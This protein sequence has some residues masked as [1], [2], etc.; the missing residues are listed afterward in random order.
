MTLKQDRE[1]VTKF[2]ERHFKENPGMNAICLPD[3]IQMI[4]DY[5]GI[6][7]GSNQ[8]QDSVGPQFIFFPEKVPVGA[9]ISDYRD[10]YEKKYGE[11]P[12]TGF[13]RHNL[14]EKIII[15]TPDLPASKEK[16]VASLPGEKHETMRKPQRDT[17]AAIPEKPIISDKLP[18]VNCE[19]THVHEGHK[20]QC[21]KKH[22]HA[23]YCV[24]E[25]MDSAGVMQAQSFGQIYTP[26][27]KDN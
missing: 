19:A 14:S 9:P 15:N 18:T 27:D 8:P 2:F 21:M 22:G 16:T 26:R 20:L 7:L 24:G 6:H 1:K 5:R 4:M 12:P 3:E 17:R 13:K 10:R 11:P 23:R 25:Y